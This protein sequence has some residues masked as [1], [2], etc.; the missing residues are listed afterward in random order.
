MQRTPYQ[1]YVYAKMTACAGNAEDAHMQ[2]MWRAKAQQALRGVGEK[3]DGGRRSPLIPSRNSHRKW[4]F[5][6][7]VIALG[8]VS[9]LFWGWVAY[10]A[11]SVMF[12]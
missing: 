3:P 2:T 5:L 7:T 10:S 8:V 12:E 9:A 6:Y 11:G 1:M 4:P